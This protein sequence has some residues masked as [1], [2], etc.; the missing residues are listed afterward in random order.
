MSA[1]ASASTR[2]SPRPRHRNADA[3]GNAPRDARTTIAYIVWLQIGALRKSSHGGETVLPRVSTVAAPAAAPGG[4]AIKGADINGAGPTERRLPVATARA[5]PLQVAMVTLCGGCD[6][7]H[8]LP[9]P[10]RPRVVEKRVCGQCCGAA[11]GAE[12]PGAAC[13]C[14]GLL[15]AIPTAGQP[16]SPTAADL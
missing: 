8:P 9:L 11:R 4:A 6:M 16:P 2:A 5:S 15:K 12:C 14:S 3:G 10:R 7:C 13:A 1:P